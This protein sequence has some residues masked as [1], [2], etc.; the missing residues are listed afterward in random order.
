MLC[1]WPNWTSSKGLPVHS[2]DQDKTVFCPGLG[3]GLFIFQ[4][5]LFGL[6]GAPSS[7][8]RLMDKVLRG[9]PFVNH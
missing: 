7:F 2:Q 5:I 9:L 6:T 3:M 1:M 4:R 8:Q